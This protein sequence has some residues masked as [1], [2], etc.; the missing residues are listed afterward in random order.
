MTGGTLGSA[1][2]DLGTGRSSSGRTVAIVGVSAGALLGI[3]G[4]VMMLTRPSPERK[5]AAALPAAPAILPA[6]TAS[7]KPAGPVVPAWTAM[8][9]T[10]NSAPHGAPTA[11]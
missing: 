2:I 1:A 4:L 8:P 5:E 11:S 7:V 6:S 10:A 3:A 9:G